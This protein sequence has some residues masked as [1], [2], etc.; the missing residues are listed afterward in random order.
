MNTCNHFHVKNTNMLPFCNKTYIHPRIS[1]DRCSMD[2]RIH[3]I[4][5]GK[6]IFDLPLEP[7]E[8]EW[9]RLHGE[10]DSL[11][12]DLSEIRAIHD[13]LSN[14]TR[15]R[16]ICE[17]VRRSDSRFSEL[18][19]R[20]DANQ[21]IISESLRRMVERSMVQRVERNPREVHYLLSRIGFASFISCLTMRRIIQE[22]D[23][24]TD[25]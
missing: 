13:I 22:L 11:E 16:M 10:L 20:V 2:L 18:M 19:E 9:E 21:K 23:D 3:L 1:F 17:M 15:F 7:E 5:D 25:L 4:K 24:E 14:E 8:W 6:V 12:R